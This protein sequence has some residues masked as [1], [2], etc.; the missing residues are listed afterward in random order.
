[1]RFGDPVPEILREADLFA[2]DL[3]AMAT[4]RS[5]GLC[6]VLRSSVPEQLLRRASGAVMLVRPGEW[7]RRVLLSW[8]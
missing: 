2:A 7:D 4:G 5:S 3:I 1:V 8:R 6:H